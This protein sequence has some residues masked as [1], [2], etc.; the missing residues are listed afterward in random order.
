MPNVSP[1]VLIIRLDGIGD[2]LALTPLLAALHRR[3]IPVDVVLR[4]SNAG[5]FASRAAR[6]VITA[7]FELRS[8]ARANLAR[9]GELGRT[10]RADAY[11]HVLVATEDPGGYRLAR[12]V[13][14][15][16][17]IGFTNVWGK[18]LKSLWLRGF[19]TE[20]VFRSA[21]LDARAPHE[22]AILFR[23]GA[24]LTGDDEPS[25]DVTEL[26]PLVLETEPKPD[27]R[28]AVQ[29]TKKWQQVGVEASDVV[30]LVRRL[31]GGGELHLLSARAERLYAEPIAGA[32]GMPVSY[33]DGVKE[34][35]DAIGAS[36]ALVAPDSG[37]IHVAGMTG[38]PVVA[39]FPAGR[40]YALQAARWAPWAAPHRIVDSRE[41]WPLR[42]ADALANLLSTV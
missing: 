38:T 35:K 14:V 30:E 40:A 1:S 16:N 11:S 3:S 26:R 9:V 31:A 18:P 36:F 4:Q 42:A 15:P 22:C 7:D 13:A 27:E 32:T 20:R 2:A 12:A 19:L 25:H 17:R 28:I 23:L 34:W 5:I 41:G 21:G 29:I 37:A 8:S 6:R 39:V 24:S 33:F 10:L